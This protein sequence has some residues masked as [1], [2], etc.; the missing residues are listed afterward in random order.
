[1][2]ILELEWSWLK[3][4]DRFLGVSII[5]FSLV[6]DAAAASVSRVF[7]SSSLGGCG[8]YTFYGFTF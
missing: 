6:L 2:F 4:G 3:F 5:L 8:A 7:V 1:L